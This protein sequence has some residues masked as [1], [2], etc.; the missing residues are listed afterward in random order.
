M[1]AAQTG[2]TSILATDLKIGEDNETKIDFEDANNINFYANNAKEMVLSEN[3]LTP[4]TSDGTALGTTSLMWSDLFLASGSVIN[5]N[6][7]DVTLTHSSNTLTVAGGTLEAS[8]ITIGGS[9]VTAGGA[10]KGFAVAMA[11]AL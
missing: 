6:N 5:F 4:G 9:S 2:I 11:I 8:A 10:S 7:G 1:A 3:A